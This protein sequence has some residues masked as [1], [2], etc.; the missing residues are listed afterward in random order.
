MPI[1]LNGNPPRPLVVL[2]RYGVNSGAIIIKLL[3]A[4]IRID[5]VVVQRVG[6]STIS[7]IDKHKDYE[8]WI[9]ERG[10][11]VEPSVPAIMDNRRDASLALAQF[12]CAKRLRWDPALQIMLEE[13][14]PGSPIPRDPFVIAMPFDADEERRSHRTSHDPRR[15]EF[16][17][18]LIEWGM[19]RDDC[20]NLC[21]TEGL[22]AM[23]G[24]CYFCPTRTKVEIAHLALSDPAAVQETLKIEN[25]LGDGV[26]MGG[27]GWKW[28]DFVAATPEQAERMGE[29]PLRHL[30]CNCYDG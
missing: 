5:M 29:P 1:S 17:Y 13:P 3:Q 15:Y 12:S 11:H 23:D 27:H 21:S 16:W 24:R 10:V 19:T 8:R 20:A 4:G 14:V 9:R 7:W 6:H 2:S 30:P 28:A 22:H 25:E 18:P 26:G